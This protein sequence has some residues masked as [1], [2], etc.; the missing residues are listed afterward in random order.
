V[1]T[2]LTDQARARGENAQ[3]VMMR[4]AI[5]RLLYRLSQTSYRDAFILKGAMLFSLWAPTPYRATGDLDLLGAGDA[6]PSRM[7]AIFRNL[8]GVEI[9]DDGV[10]FDARSV[11]AQV[12]R[13]ED[14]YSGV[15][16]ALTAMMA[17]ARLPIQV[18]IGFGDVVTPAAL[19]ISY[20]SLLGFPEAQLRAYPPET[21]VAEKLEAM[22]SLGMRNSRMKD[23]FDLWAIANTFS[24]EGEVLAR[25]VSST[26][27]QRCTPFPAEP[28]VALTDEFT[29]DA[30]K[31][32]Q[33]RAFLNRTAIAFAPA[34]LSELVAFLRTFALPLVEQDATRK[35]A[36]ARWTPG[37]PWHR[38]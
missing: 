6:A 22:V 1:R 30:G 18:D 31:Q 34:P 36:Q 13:P 5:E 38:D 4:F 32:A 7:E 25:A 37:G 16:V 8:C 21:V 27:T 3:L 2:R 35:L 15:R 9:E 14:E 33:W 23:F 26:F 17:G 20:P 28:P 12:A 29:N 19:K 24:F 10:T 11:T